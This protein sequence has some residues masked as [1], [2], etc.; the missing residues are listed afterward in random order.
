V[1][2]FHPTPA[3][4]LQLKSAQAVLRSDIFPTEQQDPVKNAEAVTIIHTPRMQHAQQEAWKTSPDNVS[5]NM[6][7]W[8][9]VKF[10]GNAPGIA[11]ARVVRAH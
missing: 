9:K 8:E 4:Y 11:L 3:K 2:R 6:D 5:A 10:A 7:T 1:H